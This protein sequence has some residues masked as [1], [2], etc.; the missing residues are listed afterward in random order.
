[1]ANIFNSEN[2]QLHGTNYAHSI[3][4]SH[5]FVHFVKANERGR[6]EEDEVRGHRRLGS[7]LRG[8]VGG[9]GGEGGG[10]EGDNPE[11]F[12]TQKQLKE[13]MEQGMAL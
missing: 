3:L 6:E 8:E 1:M 5:V 2:V 4:T 11:Q 7:M 9:G 10:G 12:E 13:K